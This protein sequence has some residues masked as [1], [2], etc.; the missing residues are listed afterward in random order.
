MGRDNKGGTSYEVEEV[1]AKVDAVI[2]LLGGARELGTQHLQELIAIKK[3]E[4]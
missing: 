4:G 1:V 2:D 3:D